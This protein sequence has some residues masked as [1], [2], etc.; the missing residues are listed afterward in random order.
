MLGRCPTSASGA[1]G[2]AGETWALF[3]VY[4][5]ICQ[6][7]W[8]DVDAAG[9]P[10]NGSASRMPSPPRPARSCF[11]PD[12]LDLAVAALLLK[13][14][15]PAFLVRYRPG[16]ASPRKSKKASD[17]PRA[18]P[19]SPASPT[20]P[21]ASSSAGCFPGRS[22]KARPLGFAWAAYARVSSSVQPPLSWL[23]AL[24][25]CPDIAGT[26]D[27]HPRIAGVAVRSMSCGSAWSA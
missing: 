5:A 22:P 1:P 6:L 17:F 23:S 3:A 8:A 13:I 24:S 25:R 9:T 16:R 4:Q 14:L 26:A 12:R 7:A 10:W 27:A 15:M 19:A 20:S 2:V 21:D 11:S 18:N